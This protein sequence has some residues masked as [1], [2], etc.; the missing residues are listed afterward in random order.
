MNATAQSAGRTL[1]RVTRR[2]ADKTWVDRAARAGLAARGVVYLLLG[3]LVARI[4]AGALGGGSTSKPAS[5]PGVAQA[6]AAQTGGRAVL[7]VLAVGLMCYALFSLGDAILHHDR[8][9]PAAK[10]WGDRAL[11]IWGFVIYGIFSGYSFYTAFSSKAGKSTAGQDQRQKTQWSARVLRW[12][13]GWLWLGLLGLVL[14][15]I[16]AFLVSRAWRRSFRPRLE[17]DE[18]STRVW[19]LAI[20]LGTLGYIGRALLFG[21]V[22]WFV[23]SAAIDDDPAHGQGV[24]GAIR[25]LADSTSGAGILSVLAALL[26]GYALYL[27]IEARYRHV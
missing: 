26:V 21:I 17:R 14:L 10:R 25:L 4:A 3:Y 6:I 16:A 18:M 19:R 11:S 23:S 24:D 5:G 1:R 12:T 22:G 20:V 8:E 2:A 9:S 15:V 27:G 13:A 7:F